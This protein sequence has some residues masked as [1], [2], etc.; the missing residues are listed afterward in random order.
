MLVLG[1]NLEVL[2]TAAVAVEAKW[3][4]HVSSVDHMGAGVFQDDGGK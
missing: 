2:I 3:V 1:R 4:L